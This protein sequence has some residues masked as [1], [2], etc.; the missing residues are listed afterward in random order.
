M[1]EGVIHGSVVEGVPTNRTL[2][3]HIRRYCIT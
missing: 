2:N 1:L 3:L